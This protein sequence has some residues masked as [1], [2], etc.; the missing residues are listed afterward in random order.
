MS[1]KCLAHEGASP[2]QRES[3]GTGGQ[4]STWKYFLQP[5]ADGRAVTPWP[6]SSS[7]VG[8]IDGMLYTVSPRHSRACAGIQDIAHFLHLG[9]EDAARADNL[10]IAAAS[11]RA[12]AWTVWREH[13]ILPTASWHSNPQSLVAAHSASVSLSRMVLQICCLVVWY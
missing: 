1:A 6:A 2:Y 5:S 8:F 13:L 10:C 9:S 3:S 12:A 7:A 11:Q 4:F